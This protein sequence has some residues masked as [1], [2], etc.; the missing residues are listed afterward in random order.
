MNKIVHRCL[1]LFS[2]LPGFALAGSFNDASSAFKRGETDKALSIFLALEQESEQVPPQLQLNIALVYLRTSQFDL[3]ADYFTQLVQAPKW[4]L[5]GKYYLGLLAHIKG[6]N[7]LAKQHLLEVVARAQN[8]PL[9]Q[10]AQKSLDQMQIQSNKN[11]ADLAKNQAEYSYLLSYTAGYENNALAL[12]RDQLEVGLPSGD[13]FSDVYFQAELPIYTHYK[14]NGYVS[15]RA[16][17]EYSDL[18]TRIVNIALEREINLWGRESIGAFDISDVWANGASIYRQWQAL[19][20]SDY[21]STLMGPVHGSI[22]V[23]KI[24]AEREYL[25][26]DGYQ[27]KLALD[28]TW[29]ISRHS[30][31]LTYIFEINDRKD[32]AVGSEFSSFSP[33]HHGITLSDKYKASNKLDMKA[34]IST[35]HSQ[36]AGTDIIL[37]ETDNLSSIKRKADLYQY[38][39]AATYHFSLNMALSLNAE[40]LDNNENIATN[41]STNSHISL[42]LEYE[43]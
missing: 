15:Y 29:T 21:H 30:I 22:S 1:L 23:Q 13:S 28:K 43:H 17:N 12:P 18:N 32:L 24:L 38:G 6:D 31:E 8:S 14:V 25:F 2:L 7:A 4:A 19:L 34:K 41:A 36:W 26:L 20:S 3:A 35:R 42:V 10:Q 27:Y 33:V 11:V 39:L 9:K 37:D 16:Y 5:I 40:Y